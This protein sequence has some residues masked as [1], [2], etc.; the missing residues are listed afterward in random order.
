VKTGVISQERCDDAVRRI[1][2]VKLRAGLW[3][4]GLPSSRPLA[5]RDEL[6]GA[7]EHRAV[8]RQIVRESLVMLK[9]KNQLLPLSP[10]LNVLV[11]GDGADNIS[12]QTAGWSVNWQGTGNT[13]ADFPGATTIWMGIESAVKAAGGKATLSVDGSFTEKPDVAV[14]V[15]GEDPYAEMQGDVQHQLL[16][17][18]DT[19]D[20]DLLKRLKAQGIPVV[21]LFI[22]GRPMWI[23]RELNASDAFVVVW[24]PGTEGGGVADVLFKTAAGEIAYPVKGRLSFSWPKTPDHGPLNIGD[25]NYDPLFAYGYGMTYGEPD[26]LGDDLNEEGLKETICSDELEIFNR[27]PIAPY[28]ILLEGKNNDR[29]VMK[30]NLAG[31]SSISVSVMDREVQEDAR[32]VIWNGE[33][34]GIVA[35]STD[36]RQVLSDYYQ[37]ES[38]LVFDV[39]VDKAPKGNVRVRIGCGPSC[40]TEV[41]VTEDFKAI[42]GK[43]WKTISI[44]LDIFPE[45]LTDFGLHR[46]PH[47]LFALVVEPFALVADDELELAFSNVR[48]QKH[49]G[50]DK[51]VAI[52]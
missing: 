48:W 16:K 27:R 21:A 51:K 50:K 15:F 9:N 52:S 6:L 43:G 2:R 34:V 31:V 7:Q 37:S 28:F 22:T 23:N 39:K 19:S 11:A 26:T 30:D 24:Q 25:D 8:A 10:Q 49:Q 32:R 33:G 4:K 35:L 13:M 20:L 44:S 46:L 3:E 18:G 40:N 36:N 1:L 38:A 42:T 14:V 29:L 47:E 5:G 17:A 45:V 12:K 41:D